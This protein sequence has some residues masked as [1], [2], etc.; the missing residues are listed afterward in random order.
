MSAN[1]ARRALVRDGSDG[2]REEEHDPPGLTGDPCGCGQLQGYDPDDREEA[3]RV[4]PDELAHLGV[5]PENGLRS[6][7]VGHRLGGV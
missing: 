3:V 5:L 7:L 4:P 6:R 2:V 1:S